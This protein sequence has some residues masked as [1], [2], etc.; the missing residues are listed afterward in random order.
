MPQLD[1]CLH[2][3]SGAPACE[4]AGYTGFATNGC[5]D[6][7][8]HPGLSETGQRGDGLVAYMTTP[9]CPPLQ[10]MCACFLGRFDSSHSFEADSMFPR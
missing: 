2:E 6:G 9:A 7:E 4:A 3:S 1:A 10:A 8:L 5:L